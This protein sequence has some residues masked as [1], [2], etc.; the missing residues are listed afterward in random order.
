MGGELDV[1]RDTYVELEREI[2]KVLDRVAAERGSD[3]P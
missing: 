3:R 1:Y 2:R